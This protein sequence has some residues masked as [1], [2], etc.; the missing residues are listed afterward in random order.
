[1]VWA[2]ARLRELEDRYVVSAGDKKPLE[3]EIVDVSLRFGVLCRFTSFVAVDKTEIVNASGLVHSI[4]Q[5]VE[6][7]EG[8]T[9][10]SLA[11][12]MDFDALE[13]GPARRGTMR[14][15]QVFSKFKKGLKGFQGDLEESNAPRA[16]APASPPACAAFPSQPIGWL[17]RLLAV[18]GSSKRRKAPPASFEPTGFR[19]WV[20]DVLRELDASPPD[21]DA[22]LQT[23]RSVVSNLETLFRNLVAAGDRRPTTQKLGETLQHLHIVLAQ[24]TPPGVDIHRVWDA[25]TATLREGIGAENPQRSGWWK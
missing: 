20:E 1:V 16:G 14:S 25:L 11:G 3:K 2:R 21:A 23:L 19:S 8:W 5:P 13:A 4:V 10:H 24:P 17:Q 18:F 12:A 15:R 22:R 6:Q 7:P 9:V